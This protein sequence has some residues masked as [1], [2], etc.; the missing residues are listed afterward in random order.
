MITF[1]SGT[2]GSG[3]SY[4]AVRDMVFKLKRP[5]HNMVLSNVAFDF[6]SVKGVK[7]SF[8]YVPNEELTPDYLIEFARINHDFSGSVRDVEGQTLVVIDECQVFFNPREFSKKDRMPWINFFTMHRH[9]GYNFIL[10]S[11]FDR[12]LDRQIRNN[13]EYEVKHRKVNNFKLGM[14]LPVPV[15]ICIE[16]WYGS[17]EKN[18]IDFLMFNKRYGNLYSSVRNI[19]FKKEEGGGVGGESG[20]PKEGPA[21][22]PTDALPL[23]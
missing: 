20:R 13:I 18:S 21:E 14:F 1:Y 10:I 15:F 23:T 9:L 3:K 16:Y 22:P 19:L 7:G 17:R 12:L 8:V 4:H 11:Q 5:D 2:P 6:S